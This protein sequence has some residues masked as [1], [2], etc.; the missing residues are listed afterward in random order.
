MDEL[1]TRV[2]EMFGGGLLGPLMIIAGLLGLLLA[3]KAAK[4]VVRMA[5]LA[6]TAILLLGA[7]PWAGQ[8]VAGP[9]ATCATEAVQVEL[10]AIR[11]TITK[12]IT[13][14]EISPDATC[15]PT[16]QGLA[17]G[18]ATVR[19]RTVFDLPYATWEVDASGARNTST[20]PLAAP[21][22]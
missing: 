18:T 17:T 1:L 16:T 2:S 22:G 11:E 20:G 12:R 8:D 21:M 14:E 4:F 13:V 9:A 3:W 10:D 6:A 15:T 19:L 5:A 7:V